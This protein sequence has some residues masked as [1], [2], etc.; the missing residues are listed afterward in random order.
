MS[1]PSV[2]LAGVPSRVGG[3]L[4]AALGWLVLV[5]GLS[6]ALGAGLLFWALFRIMALALA[7]ALPMALV[8]LGVGVTLLLVSRYL[9]RRGALRW[10]EAREQALLAFAAQCGSCTAAEGGRAL[11]I[12]VAE[13]DRILTDVAKR[14]PE[15][16]AVDVGDDGKVRYRPL[17]GIARDYPDSGGRA[18]GRGVRVS[19]EVARDDG[20]G[21]ED[22]VAFESDESVNG[23]ATRGRRR[24]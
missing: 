8:A 10:R 2:N 20:N 21:E 5:L 15:R 13:A 1:A 12:S 7:F 11:G 14:E 22:E 18:Y 23:G 3:T 4:A 9:G 16:L 24:V 17:E 19:D 6:L